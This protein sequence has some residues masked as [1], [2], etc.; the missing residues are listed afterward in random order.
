MAEDTAFSFYINGVKV[1][2]GMDQTFPN[3]GKIGLF[4]R[5]ATDQGFTVGYDSLA[6]WTLPRPTANDP[7]TSQA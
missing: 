1:T 4:V 5:P 3:A 7:V 2:E 6:V